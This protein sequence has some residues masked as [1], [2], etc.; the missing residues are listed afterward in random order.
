MRSG[1]GPVV[2]SVECFYDRLWVLRYDSEQCQCRPLSLGVTCGA[3]S[4]ALS[5]SGRRGAPIGDR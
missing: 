3:T 1:G 5:P 2:T 4:T